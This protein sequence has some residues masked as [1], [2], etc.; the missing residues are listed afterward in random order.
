M[1]GIL[2]ASVSLSLSLLPPLPRLG[3]VGPRSLELVL[4]REDPA[5][6]KALQSV[7]SNGLSWC[8]RE[9]AYMWPHRVPETELKA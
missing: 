1:S 8:P 5:R 4:L 9:R 3:Q 7:R 6:A 2:S